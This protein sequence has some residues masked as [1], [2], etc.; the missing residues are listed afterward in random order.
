MADIIE[1]SSQIKTI[2]DRNNVQCRSLAAL[3][4]GMF[5]RFVV[6]GLPLAVL[7]KGRPLRGVVSAGIDEENFEIEAPDLVPYLK[8]GALLLVVFPGPDGRR[9]VI[10]ARVSAVKADGCRVEC[11]DPRYGKRLRPEGEVVVSWRRVPD[12]VELALRDGGLRVFRSMDD[13]V[14][15]KVAADETDRREAPGFETSRGFAVLADISGGGAA[16]FSK[17]EVDG[18]LADHLLYIETDK[19]A[20]ARLGLFAVVRG[21]S[22]RDGGS[23]IHLMFVA[24]IGDDLAA[25]AA[26]KGGA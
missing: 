4:E 17:E 16:L 20:P 12:E 24:R 23:L 26:G 7:F 13:G 9:Y 25:A 1:I 11:L 15:E 19:A 22:G 18:G 6:K 5:E 3:P 10:Q 21:V 14:V 8:A 2:I